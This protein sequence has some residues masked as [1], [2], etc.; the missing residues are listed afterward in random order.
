VS[1]ALVIAVGVLM[2]TGSL[3]RLATWFSF[4]NRFAL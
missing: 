2:V 1:G 4:L 3:T